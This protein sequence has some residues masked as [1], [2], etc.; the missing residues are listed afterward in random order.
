MKKLSFS[1]L[2]EQALQVA[3]APVAVLTDE[4]MTLAAGGALST[5]NNVAEA[6]SPCNNVAEALSPCNNVAEALSP[7]NNVL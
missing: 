6:L 5:C 2:H 3:N 1:Q 4:Q 7:C